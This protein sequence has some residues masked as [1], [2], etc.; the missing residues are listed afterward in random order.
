MELTGTIS[1]IE[2]LQV[3]GDNQ[4][5][6][7][8]LILKTDE[9]YPQVLKIQFQQNNTEQLKLYAAGESVKIAI[10]LKGRELTNKQGE[11]VVYNNIV[12]WKIQK[13]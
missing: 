9:Q 6:T 5:K 2:A 1:R 10:N 7:Q 11:L 12:G 4:F 8:D 3:V 13:L